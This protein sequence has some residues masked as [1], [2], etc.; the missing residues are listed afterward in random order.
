MTSQND[1][2]AK[3]VEREQPASSAATS[4]RERAA[5]ALPLGSTV[6]GFTVTSKKALPEFDADAY[7][8]HHAAS[9]AR[10]LYLACDDENKAFSI[11]FKTP[12]PTT[13]AS[14]TSSSTRCCADRSSSP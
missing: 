12:P 8:M 14:S 6:S 9:G 1:Q 4:A 7:V 10:L 2:H 5:S 13:R 11:G 3:A